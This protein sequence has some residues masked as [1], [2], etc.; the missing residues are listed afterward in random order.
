MPHTSP[1]STLARRAALE[2]E[3][4]TR[5]AQRDMRVWRERMAARDSIMSNSQVQ[6]FNPTYKE[7]QPARPSL[8]PF[9]P[10][11]SFSFGRRV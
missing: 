2:A 8:S 4:L 6:R 9:D 3:L 11:A 1:S 7:N 10:D 5:L